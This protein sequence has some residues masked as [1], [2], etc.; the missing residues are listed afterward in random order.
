MREAGGGALAVAAGLFAQIDTVF[1][2]C[3]ADEKCSVGKAILEKL[4]EGP[5][6][7]DPSGAGGNFGKN[8]EKLV[9]GLRHQGCHRWLYNNSGYT[10]KIIA[11][12]YDNGYM[13]NGASECLAP[14]F[15][16]VAIHWRIVAP[17]LLQ[18]P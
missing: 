6:P 16:G 9:S 8:A 15:M 5:P 1:A 14:P 12:E 7:L 11:P 13:C 18:R 10:W 3:G 17:G 4:S 2:K